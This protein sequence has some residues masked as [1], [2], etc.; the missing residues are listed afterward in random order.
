MQNADYSIGPTL[1]N[2]KFFYDFYLPSAKH[3]RTVKKRVGQVFLI[4]G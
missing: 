2:K 4:G 3:R 1:L